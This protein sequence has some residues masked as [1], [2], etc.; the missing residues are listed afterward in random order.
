MWFTNLYFKSQIRNLKINKQKKIW[1]TNYKEFLRN[2]SLIVLCISFQVLLLLLLV[3][4][5]L[6]LLLLCFWDESHYVAWAQLKPLGTS[7][8]SW[9]AGIIGTCHA[10]QLKLLVL[11][12][13]SSNFKS[14]NILRHL[15]SSLAFPP[16]F[17]YPLKKKKQV[18]E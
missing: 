3:L 18:V 4:L 12:Y 14:N 6:L 16:R 5:L 15:K 7:L 17:R 11:C 10:T 9:V 8:A 1:K 2:N 13:V